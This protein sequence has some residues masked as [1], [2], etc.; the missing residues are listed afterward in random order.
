MNGDRKLTKY[1]PFI[2]SIIQS[3]NGLNSLSILISII[4]CEWWIDSLRYST[5]ICILNQLSFIHWLIE[6][7]N[8]WMSGLCDIEE[9]DIPSK[10]RI[11]KPRLILLRTTTIKYQTHPIWF[12]YYQID[13]SM[14]CDSLINKQTNKQMIDSWIDWMVNPIWFP[15]LF[16]RI[17]FYSILVS[18]PC[19]IHFTSIWFYSILFY[20]YSDRFLFNKSK[21][22]S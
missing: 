6:W 20:V 9:Y 10:Y 3:I 21:S 12:H 15:M 11:V 4:E 22:I 14:F 2:Q 18:L 13:K 16:N 5:F 7:V 17:L 8:E 1:T 19:F